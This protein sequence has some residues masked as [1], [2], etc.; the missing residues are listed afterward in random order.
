MHKSHFGAV[1]KRLR[2][3]QGLTQ[4]RLASLADLERTF[5]SM[6]ERGI[7]Q[8]SLN[9]ISNVA[10]ALGIKN[11]ELLHLVEQEFPSGING[12]YGDQDDEA[13]H[14]QL[15]ALEEAEEKA[16]IDEIANTLPVVFFART[17]LP[18]YAA[19]FISKNIRQLLGYDREKLI[20]ARQLWLDHVHPEDQA[21]V[22]ER[23][24]AL[25]PHAL[26]NH[27]YRLLSGDGHWV[28]VREEL[29][30]VTDESGQAKEVLGSLTGE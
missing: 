2:V 26:L 24:A 21:I 16:R 9:T 29:K 13:E 10:K 17:P 8:P 3:Q 30:I 22:L 7:K 14:R 5:V 28:R 25:K 4:E 19:T 15:V 6:L 1:I 20:G 11:Y 12:H 23:I 27:E 18:E